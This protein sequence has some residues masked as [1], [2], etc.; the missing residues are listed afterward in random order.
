MSEL[1]ARRGRGELAVV[2]SWLLVPIPIAGWLFAQLFTARIG[3]PSE[4]AGAYVHTL[5]TSTFAVLLFLSA[6]TNALIVSFRS[7]DRP[8]S[9]GSRGYLLFQTITLALSATWLLCVTIGAPA[10]LA[11]TIAGGA[12]A[13]VSIAVFVL[14][15][16]RDEVAREH[17]RTRLNQRDS[18][19]TPGAIRRAKLGRFI[20]PSA[21]GLAAIAAVIVVQSVPIVHH[22]CIIEGTGQVN[23][24]LDFYTDCGNFAVN[25]SKLTS[26]QIDDFFYSRNALDITTR[27]Y[28]FSGGIVPVAV[29]IVSANSR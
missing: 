11:E 20:Y 26:E 25:L 16:W 21:F 3:L 28:T 15:L 5:A 1:L 19:R 17:R 13:I 29:D 27:G 12:I 23:G 18:L 10:Q 7:V 8:Q 2:L 24:S 14:A 4:F 6:V 22:G 9:Y